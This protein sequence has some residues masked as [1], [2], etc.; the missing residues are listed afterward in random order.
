[1]REQLNNNPKVQM[2]AVAFLVIAAAFFLLTMGGGEKKSEG[3]EVVAT[4]NGATATGSTPGE[5]VDSAVESLGAPEA[6][7]VPAAPTAVPVPPIAPPQRVVDAWR[8][9]ETVVLVFVREGGIDDRLVRDSAGVLSRLQ[10]VTT[11]VVPAKQI[12]RYSGLTSRVGVDRVPAVV[13]LSPKNISG[14]TTG[15]V[16]Y[17]YQE[18]ERITQAVVDAGYEG[19]TLDYHP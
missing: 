7:A 12:A 15:A 10:N 6:G 13:V 18:P 4:V 14:P 9:G 2:G 8:S 16:L 17:G 3:G 19:P 1:M 11:F 5:A